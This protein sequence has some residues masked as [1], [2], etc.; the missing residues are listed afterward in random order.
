MAPRWQ[1]ER[2]ED[3]DLMVE[4]SHVQSREIGL[5]LSKK[6]VGV[7]LIV[8]V[9]TLGAAVCWTIG[10]A[11]L[12]KQHAQYAANVL[13][14]M[15]TLLNQDQQVV[16]ELQEAPFIENGSDILESYLTKIRRDGVAKHANMKQ[17][18]DQLAENNV[19]I[20]TLIKVYAP[21][22]KTAN[23]TSEADKFRNYA[24]AWN[25][26]WN[27]VMEIFMAG[28]NYPVTGIPFPAG[29]PATIEAEIAAAH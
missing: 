18:L 13:R 16:S 7:A 17:L 12:G 4:S 15:A 14:P 5:A 25:D 11:A 27:S 23:F 20:V 26:R 21:L 29:F 19:A 22:A 8:A 10:S 1:I 28:G 24:S 2:D 3:K 9:A 6:I